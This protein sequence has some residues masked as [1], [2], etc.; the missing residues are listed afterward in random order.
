MIVMVPRMHVLLADKFEQSGQ[1]GLKAAS[2]EVTF[3]P[4]LKDD[5]LAQAVDRLR[6]DV[7]VVRSTKVTVAI[8]A[9]GPME[10]GGVFEG[11]RT[12]RP[13]SWPDRRGPDRTRDDSAREGFRHARRCVEPQL[14][15]GGSHGTRHCAPGIAHRSGASGRYRERACGGESADARTDRC[16]LL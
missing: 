6:P 16:R 12:A 3:Q 10:Q 5:A 9:A 13:H 8:L 7:L 15:S 1:D 2:C 14:D 11:P 4:G